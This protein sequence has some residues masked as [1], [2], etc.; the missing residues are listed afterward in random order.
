MCV[1]NNLTLTLGDYPELFQWAQYNPKWS[2]KVEEARRRGK[3]E[4]TTW[5][6]P[7]Q[8]LL[9]LKTEE[10]DGPWAKECGQP[11]ETRK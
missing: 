3:R 8:T 4:I 5:A 10:G 11:Q 9:A 1:A 7:G 6:G 2:L